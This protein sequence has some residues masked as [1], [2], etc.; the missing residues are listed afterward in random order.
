MWHAANTDERARAKVTTAEDIAAFAN[1]DGGCLLVGIRDDKTIAGIGDTERDR[2]NRVK[3]LTDT[4]T[5]LIQY[6]RQIWKVH[7]LLANGADGKEKLCLVVIAARACEPVGV[8]G[9]NGSYTYPVRHG[10]GIAREDPEK[11]RDARIHDK[12]DNFDFLERLR[13]FVRDN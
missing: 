6:P 7:Q 5:E 12:N 2:E 1:S 8:K 3:T 9:A 13:Q 10:T 11:L 4:L